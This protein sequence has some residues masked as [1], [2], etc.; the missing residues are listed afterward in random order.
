MAVHEDL[1]TVGSKLPAGYF[2]DEPSTP[3]NWGIKA[4]VNLH[5]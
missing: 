3:I 4:K 1:R 2:Q 5:I